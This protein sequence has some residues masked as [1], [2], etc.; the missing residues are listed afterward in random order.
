[1]G[2]MTSPG[3]E[4]AKAKL[5]QYLQEAIK[6]R[7]KKQYKEALVVTL[8]SGEYYWRQHQP[9]RAAGLLL[10]ATDLFY[11]QNNLKAGQRCLRTALELM[12]QKPQLTWWEN[13]L[14]GNLFLLTACLSIITNTVSVSTQLSNYRNS[15]LKKQQARLSREDGYRVAIALRRA[16]NRRSLAPLDNLETKTTLRSRSEYATLYEHLQGMS[17]RYVIIRDALTALRREIHQEDV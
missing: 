13:E 8:V 9:T 1:M 4:V 2:L 11:L 15:L 3:L 5:G 17:E 16:I 12:T 14:I 7:N 6:L 10:E